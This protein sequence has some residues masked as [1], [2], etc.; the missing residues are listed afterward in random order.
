MTQT[1]S[2]SLHLA[3]FLA[4]SGHSGVDR[5]MKNLLPAIADQ[6]IKLDLLHVEN[7]GPYLEHSHAN[8]RVINLGSSHVNTSFPALLRYLK[9]E[10]PDVVLSD[11]DKVNRLVI[12]ARLFSRHRCRVVVRM[13]TT[14]SVNLRDRSWL[15]R[16]TQYLSIRLFYRFADGIIMPSL[17]AAQDLAKIAGLPVQRITVVPSPVITPA[18]EQKLQMPV[19]HP[20]LAQK[21]VPVILGIGELSRRKDFATLV[22]AFA[23]VRRQ[24]EVRL[25]ILGRGREQANLERL[26]DELKIQDDVYLAGF[27]DN[28]YAW[29]ARADVFALTSICEGAPVALMEAMGAGIPSVATD[30]PSGPFEILEGGRLGCLAPIGDDEAVSTGLI[31]MLDQPPPRAELLQAAQRYTLAESVRQ[32]LAVMKVK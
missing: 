16:W 26:I 29:L 10:Q 15:Q 27:Q 4:T 3:V 12:L 5:V 6:G 7:H 32:Y 19:A 2:S 1:A 20:W 21:S 13:G 14:V 11:K 22:R 8:I 31:R 9:T 28:P 23:R 24:R 17:G 18:F 25:I 30:C